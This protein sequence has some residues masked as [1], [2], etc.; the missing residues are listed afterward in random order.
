MGIA[1]V[2]IVAFALSAFGGDGTDAASASNSPF[3][4]ATTPAPS[5]SLTTTEQLCL[6]L[7][8]LVLFR[9]DNYT[10]LAAE[11][12]DDAA[13]IQASGDAKLAADVTTMRT[14]VL[15]YRDALA[16]QA[17]TSAASVQISKALKA[18]PCS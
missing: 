7:R 14:A 5:S 3:A 13:A 8:D 2:L 10:H 15:A 9:V 4:V 6:H 18:L 16:A 17:D 11:L 12:A 1:A